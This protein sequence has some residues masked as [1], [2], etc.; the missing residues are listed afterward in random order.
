MVWW[1]WEQEAG[2]NEEEKIRL[3]VKM[4]DDDEVGRKNKR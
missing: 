1:I 4:E 3:M 2:R